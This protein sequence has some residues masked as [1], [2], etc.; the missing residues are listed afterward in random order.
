MSRSDT[1]SPSTLMAVTVFRLTISYRTPSL[2]F[3]FS[4]KATSSLADGTLSLPST[5]TQRFATIHYRDFQH[6]P[7]IGLKTEPRRYVQ[8]LGH[9]S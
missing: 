4:H 1:S 6:V 8:Q 7:R 2:G 5:I 9:T 3:A